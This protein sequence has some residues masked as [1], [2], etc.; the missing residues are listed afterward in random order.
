MQ[1]YMLQVFNNLLVMCIIAI[2]PLYYPMITWPAGP[3]MDADRK[4]KLVRDAVLPYV[5]VTALVVVLFV[6]LFAGGLLPR[7]WHLDRLVAFIL[8][9][10]IFGFG[11]FLPIRFVPIVPQLKN[12]APKSS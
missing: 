8:G 5:R 1:S 12:K 9:Q 2:P 3:E 11:I 6:A 10:V 7:D 4:S